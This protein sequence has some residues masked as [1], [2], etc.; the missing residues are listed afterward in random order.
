[1]TAR[2]RILPISTRDEGQPQHYL[3]LDGTGITKAEADRV[4]STLGPK[5]TEAGGVLLVFGD[6]VDLPEVDEDPEATWAEMVRA[7]HA[8]EMAYKAEH[9]AADPDTPGAVRPKRPK[10]SEC[11]SDAG[12]N[13][14]SVQAPVNTEGP[15]EPDYATQREAQT[16]MDAKVAAANA[17]SAEAPAEPVCKASREVEASGWVICD[18]Q[19]HDREHHSGRLT[20]GP[21]VGNRYAWPF[22]PSDR[23]KLEEPQPL[24][25]TV[26]VE[27]VH[28]LDPGHRV[29][30]ALREHARV[31]A[32]HA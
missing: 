27:N 7:E 22:G 31:T 6:Q 1:V 28:P 8:R 14:E 13:A 21:S 12:H 9:W 2:L 3:I 18:G 20:T 15:S 16:S 4:V 5:V 24:G 30:T 23:A 11:A 10:C 17:V 19:G 26:N 32:R 29:L 25:F